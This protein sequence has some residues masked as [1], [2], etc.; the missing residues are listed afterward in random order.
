MT[1]R[2]TE[3]AVSD[4]AQARDHYRALDEELEHRFLN[5]LDTVIDRLVTF[6]N[7]DVSDVE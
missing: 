1:V 2:L 3:L 6:P 4:L 7:R 5:Q